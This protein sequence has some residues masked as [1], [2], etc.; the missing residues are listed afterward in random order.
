MAT[1]MNNIK[2]HRLYAANIVHK[3]VWAMI[4]GVP[5]KAYL[6][7]LAQLTSEYFAELIEGHDEYEQEKQRIQESRYSS[8]AS[9]NMVSTT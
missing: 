6:Q 3:N 5:D 8:E 4:E 7:M 1:I 9:N 2:L